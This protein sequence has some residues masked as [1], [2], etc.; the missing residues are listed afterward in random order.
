[1]EA[2]LYLIPGNRDD[3]STLR[4]AFADRGYLPEE[5]GFLH[6]TVEDHPLRL[7]AI[8]STLSGER[9]GVFCPA[10]AAWLD[11]TLRQQPERPTLLFIHHPPFD[12]G[13]HYVGGYRRPG[14]AAALGDVVSRHAQVR[15]LL[16]GHVHRLTETSWSGTSARVMTSIAADV[17]IDI[18]SAGETPVY[19]LHDV[20]EENGLVSRAREIGG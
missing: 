15:G 10:R 5:G 3:N 18:D 13:D 4:T 7:V 16:C 2:P 14:E 19:L 12:I 1:M 20:S 17:R 6:Y 11:A 9:M 8:D